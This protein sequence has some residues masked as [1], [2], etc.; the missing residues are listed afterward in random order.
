[1]RQNNIVHYNAT[2]TPLP[3]YNS[4]LECYSDNKYADRCSLRA[5]LSCIRS[6]V[7]IHGTRQNF[8]QRSKTCVGG[9]FITYRVD[10]WWS[11]LKNKIQINL[12]YEVNHSISRYCSLQKKLARSVW[13]SWYL[14]LVWNGINRLDNAYKRINDWHE[15]LQ[16]CC[17]FA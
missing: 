8:L 10:Q 11:E 13:K 14:T 17:D 9:S 5:G 15:L 16:W 6:Q 3:T 7:I 2:T 12:R 1:M 4:M